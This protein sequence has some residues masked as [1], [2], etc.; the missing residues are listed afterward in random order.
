MYEPQITLVGNLTA[1]PDLRYV[2]SGTPV[3]SFTLAS[4]PKTKNRDGGYDDGEPLFVR[5]NVWREFAENVTET[6]AKGMR[7]IVTGRLHRE[8]YTRQDGTGGESLVLDV[9]GL[10]PDLRYATAQVTKM[11]RASFASADSYGVGCDPA[12]NLGQMIDPNP[13]F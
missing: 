7:V 4:T 6:L 1:D 5:C 13:P 2:G 12:G 10:G 9:D 8:R 11:V 3:A